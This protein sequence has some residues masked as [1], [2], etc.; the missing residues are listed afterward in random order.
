MAYAEA[1]VYFDGSH[2]IAIPHTTRPSKSRNTPLEERVEVKADTL[3]DKFNENATESTA[4]LPGYVPFELEEIKVDDIE[5]VFGAFEN[6]ETD[7][8]DNSKHSHGLYPL[9]KY[10]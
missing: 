3:K 2:Y 7:E 4:P 9:S 8:S 5:D 10:D 1:K 6:N